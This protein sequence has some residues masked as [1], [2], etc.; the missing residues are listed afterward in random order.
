MIYLAPLQ[1]LTD[2][3]FRE[4]FQKSFGGIDVCFI[5]YLSVKNGA[6]PKRQLADALPE[7][8]LT[9]RAVP[10]VLFSDENEL[11]LLI[12]ILSGLGYREINLNLGCPYPMVANRGRGAGLLSDPDN[13]FKI[14]RRCI[15]GSGINFSVKLR[16]GLNR[17][18]EIFPIIEV[19]NQFDFSEIIYHPRVARQ[20]YKG[21]P[22]FEA[23]PS[24]LELSKHPV[25][26]NGDIFSPEVYQSLK[27]RFP[28]VSNWMLGRGIL[29]NPFLAEEIS[30]IE[31]G[32]AEKMRRL[33]QFHGQLSESYSK[34]LSGSGHLLD[35]MRQ[36]WE[37]FSFAFENRHKAFKLVKK[38][39]TLEKYNAAIKTIFRGD[40]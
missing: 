32:K 24:V 8:N 19:L 13:L 37:Y 33:S 39:N 28:A 25:G 9:L 38:A 14:L 1:G 17:H 7:N 10:Q 15:P 2:Y 22:D 12:Q 29:M 6:V 21:Q 23:V 34:K 18:D 3:I 26:L 30:G 27:N 5:P 11:A 20:L 36:F 4:T 40:F 35:K 31:T 16:S